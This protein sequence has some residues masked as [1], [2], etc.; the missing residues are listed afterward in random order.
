MMRRGMDVAF[1]PA[2]TT[3]LRN[4]PI[5]STCNSTTSPLSQ[6]AAD[7]QPAAIADRAGAEHLAGVDRLV[8]RGVGEDLR[9]R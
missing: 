9:E 4:T 8:L 2:R 6:E 5:R 1:S 7:L 3:R